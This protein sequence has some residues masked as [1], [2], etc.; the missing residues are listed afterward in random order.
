MI[1]L[2]GSKINSSIRFITFQGNTPAPP[3]GYKLA[4]RKISIHCISPFLKS[5]N[6][7]KKNELNVKATRG[8]K[9]LNVNQKII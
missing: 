1:I 8:G 3:T 7:T 6:V 2:Y 5:F 9:N 4:Y